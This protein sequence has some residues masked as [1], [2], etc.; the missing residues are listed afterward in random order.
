MKILVTGSCGFIGFHTC[1]R[2]LQ[3]NHIVYGIDAMNDYYDKNLKQNNLIDLQV[4]KN[5]Y[6]IEDD[7]GK[8]DILSTEEIDVVIHLGAYAGVR[9]S[10]E[11]PDLYIQNNLQAT[12]HLLEESVKN[13]I[14]LFLFAS[15]SSVYG[16][17]DTPFRETDTIDKVNSIYAW[18]KKSMEDLCGLYHR[19]YKLNC[20]GMRFFT[21]Y[22]PRGRPDMAPM[23]FLDAIAQNKP[24]H[25]YG[26]GSSSRDYTYIDDIVDGIQGLMNHYIDV[27]KFEVFN[28]GNNEVT[29]L[30]EFIKMCEDVT[31]NVAKVEIVDNQKGDVPKT[32]ANIDKAKRII[33]YEPKVSVFQGLRRTFIWLQN[34]KQNKL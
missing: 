4:Y 19:L 10:L 28:L 9:K 29:T 23:K 3:E 20:I 14:K 11:C 6:F 7:M 16:L 2:L 26:D 1:S 8:T 30:S 17:N 24:I 12:C 13:E 33:D 31:G 5:F 22:G 18:T 15:S 34:N 32:Y 25:Q 27:I 21:V